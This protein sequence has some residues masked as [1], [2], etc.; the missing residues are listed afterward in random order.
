MLLTRFDVAF[1]GNS[2][3]KF[4]CRAFSLFETETR[5]TQI[6]TLAILWYASSTTNP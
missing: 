3:H 1:C 2:V 4:D 5:G 6:K